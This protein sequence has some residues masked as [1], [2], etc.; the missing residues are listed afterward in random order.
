[1]G[2]HIISKNTV[3]YVVSTKE[4]KVDQQ[5]DTKPGSGSIPPNSVRGKTFRYSVF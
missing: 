3:F 5:V 2:Y 4:D 1:M